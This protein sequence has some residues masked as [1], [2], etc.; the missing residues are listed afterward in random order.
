MVGL[1]TYAS[2]DLTATYFVPADRF[3]PVVTF[4][5][6]AGQGNDSLGGLTEVSSPWGVSTA[7]RAFRLTGSPGTS[8]GPLRNIHRPNKLGGVASCL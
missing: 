8:G 5:P 1:T 2:H 6:S 7:K 4:P 3:G